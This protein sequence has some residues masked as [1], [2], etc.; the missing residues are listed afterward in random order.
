MKPAQ[1]AVDPQLRRRLDDRQ[2]RDEAEDRRQRCRQPRTHDAEP[3]RAEV[4]EDKGPAGQGVEQD[5]RRHHPQAGA[6]LAQGVGEVAQHHRR[7]GERQAERQHGDEPAGVGRQR[8]LLAERQQERPGRPQHQHHRRRGE[9]D[10]PQTHPQ[11]RAHAA[12][13]ARPHPKTMRDHRRHRR[14]R[15]A[16]HQ[17]AE[18]VNGVSDRRRRQGALAQAA[19]EDDV[20][21]HHR[22]LGELGRRQRT[23]ERQQGARLYG[24]GPGVLLS[25]GG[26]E[27]GGHGPGSFGSSPNRVRR[28]W[29]NKNPSERPRLGGV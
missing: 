6:R 9:D 12:P 23:G 27:Y 19:E 20:G 3:G 14:G 25:N 4:T 16:A 11:R 18:E 24:P 1:H 5:R 10:S 15:S 8:R 13:R 28:K 22:H 7:Q 26:V 17:P 29:E 2:H 21:G